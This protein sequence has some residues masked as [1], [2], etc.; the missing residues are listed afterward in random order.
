V[1]PL[2][3]DT[4]GLKSGIVSP[5][6]RVRYST[7][8][9]EPLFSLLSY[10]TAMSV[11]EYQRIYDEAFE[12]LLEFEEVDQELI[13]DHLNDYDEKAADSIEELYYGLLVSAQNRQAMPN[14][15]G[16][17]SQLEDLLY[18]F[19]PKNVVEQYTSWEDFFKQVEQSDEVSPPG[20]FEIDNPYSHWVQFSKSVISAGEFLSDYNDVGEVDEL[21]SDTERGDESTRLDV[22]LLL[23]DEVH[24]IG[25]ATGCDFLKENGYP[26]FVK[27]DVHIRDIFEGAGISEP[28][29]DDIELFEDA[30][31]FARTIDV[32]PYKVDKLFWIVGSGRFPE[33]STPDGSEFTITT[34]KDDFLSRL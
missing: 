4:G 28:D 23:S 10:S 32:L 6:L 11:E 22:P 7:R 29:T 8:Q 19:D 27:P 24:G 12:Y 9:L 33:V 16:D 21:I 3:T 1:G 13:L 17:I 18:G 34:D 14:S 31:K 30:I 15:I 2:E 5:W 20:R 26:E 25:F